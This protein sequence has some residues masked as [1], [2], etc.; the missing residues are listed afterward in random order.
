MKIRLTLLVLLSVFFGACS[1]PTQTP[2]STNTAPTLPP[3]Q[4]MTATPFSPDPTA[5]EASTTPTPILTATP[6]VV[7]PVGGYGP[8]NFPANINPLTGLP[9]SD[10]AILDRRPLAVKITL[11]PRSSRPQWGLSFADHVYE[12]HQNGSISRFHAIFYGTDVEK[13]G[14]VRSARLFDSNLVR[15][16]KSIFAFGG[17]DIVV[18]S[19]VENRVAVAGL[20][21]Y[22]VSE[23]PAGCGPMCRI[24]PGTYSHLVTNTKDLSQYIT[25]LGLENGRQNLNGLRFD[26]QAPSDGQA[27]QTVYVRFGPQVYNR[28]DYN[29]STSQYARFQDTRD[30]LGAG[31]DYAPMIDQLTNQQ[32]TV[33]NVVV[34]Q[35]PQGYYDPENRIVDI[36]MS[37]SGQAFAF[38]DG[39][40]YDV[41]WNLPTPDSLP[42]LTYPDG[43]LFPLKP[44][45]TWYQIIGTSSIITRPQGNVWRFEFRIP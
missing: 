19:I 4:L 20:A 44:G 3:P 25:N 29:A 23:Y 35:V 16:Y 9:V 10:P 33:D 41:R 42:F 24:I 12:Y 40:V 1:T 27:V 36:P 18:L 43:S 11:M 32:V 38:R 37:G 8:D 2:E 6:N 22:L 26:L 13:I 7:L 28:W 15:M 30:D 45:R 17:A 31:E 39:Q 21:S 14:P 5:T 34:L